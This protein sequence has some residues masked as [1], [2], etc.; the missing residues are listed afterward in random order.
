MTS[1]DGD[2]GCFAA[3]PSGRPFRRRDPHL[4]VLDVVGPPRRGRVNPI[5]EL[6]V[7]H[8]LVSW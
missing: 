8:P 1:S 7:L 5:D 6:R 2:R 4:A 3:Q